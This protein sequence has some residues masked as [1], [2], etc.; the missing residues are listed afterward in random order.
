MSF[1]NGCR[2][3]EPLTR[4]GNRGDEQKGEDGK[5]DLFGSRAKDR[6]SEAAL[7]FASVNALTSDCGPKEKEEPIECLGRE[8]DGDGK[9]GIAGIAKFVCGG[10][11][12]VVLLNIEL[13]VDEVQCQFRAQVQTTRACL[14]R[15]LRQTYPRG[16]ILVPLAFPYLFRRIQL[17]LASD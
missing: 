9:F 16:P 14:V 3:A 15:S 17:I 1:A 13:D 11:V 10:G 6:G 4:R 12:E 7:W 2:L 5:I 8:L